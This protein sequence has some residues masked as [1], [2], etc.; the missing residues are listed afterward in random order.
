MGIRRRLALHY[1]KQKHEFAVTPRPCSFSMGGW[2]V[3]CVSPYE[4]GRREFGCTIHSPRSGG[5]ERE[6]VV[7]IQEMSPSLPA[8]AKVPF[9]PPSHRPTDRATGQPD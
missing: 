6:R 5:G 7:V 8:L 3:V 2:L 1:G 9:P 4:K